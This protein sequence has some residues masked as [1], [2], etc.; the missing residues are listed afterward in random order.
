MA[1][2]KGTFKERETSKNSQPGSFKLL[3]TAYRCRCGFEWMNKRN[4]RDRAVKPNVCPKCRSTNWDKPYKYRRGPDGK[5]VS[6]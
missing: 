2:N 6:D 5:K 4:V 1:K 3:V